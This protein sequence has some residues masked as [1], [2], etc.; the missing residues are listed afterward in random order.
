MDSPKG[1]PTVTFRNCQLTDIKQRE[2]PEQLTLNASSGILPAVEAS[3]GFAIRSE[4]CNCS[5]E[6]RE[7]ESLNL[8]KI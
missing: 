2:I 4:A 5:Y 1:V 7:C 6:G 3:E 8:M